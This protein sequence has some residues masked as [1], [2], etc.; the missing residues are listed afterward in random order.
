MLEPKGNAIGKLTLKWLFYE[1]T[2]D[3]GSGSM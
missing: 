1:G 2:A 3:L